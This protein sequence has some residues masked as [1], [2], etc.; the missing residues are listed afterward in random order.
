MRLEVEVMPADEP[1]CRAALEWA[2]RLGQARAYDGFFFGRFD[3]RAPNAEAFRRGE[4]LR[5][6]ELNGVTSEATHIYEPGASLLAGWRTLFE[7]WR[8]AFEIGR[9]NVARGAR[10]ATLGELLRLLGERRRRSATIPGS[11]GD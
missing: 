2:A 11:R 3:L 10:P 1:L 4:G 7:Q 9:E 6:I 8:L 5:V